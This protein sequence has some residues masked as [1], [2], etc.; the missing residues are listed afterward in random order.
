MSKVSR[1]FLPF[2]IALFCVN[3]LDRVNI[4]F[5]ALQMN[6]DLG[7][8]PQIYGFAAGILF[9]S[10]TA[11]EIP[12]NMILAKVGARI[13]IARIMI[14]WGIVGMATAFVY[15]QY[16]LYVLRFALGAAEAGFSPGIIFFLTLWFPAEE[17]ASA[18][19]LYLIGNPI[20]V[21]IGAPLSTALLGL[22][23]YLGLH[24][25]QWLFLLEGAPA[26]VLGIATLWVLTDAPSQ[27]NWLAADEREWLDQ[28]VTA[29]NAAKAKTAHMNVWQVLSNPALLAFSFVKFCVLVAFFGVTLWLP[30]IVKAMGNLTNF[31]V[32]LISAIPYAFSAVMSVAVSRHSDKTGELTLHI[33]VP[34]LLGCA[35][36]VLAAITNNP[37]LGLI[38]LCFAATGVWIANTV[39]WAMP[40][41][42]LTGTAAATGF[43][44][45]NSVGNLGGF[46]GPYFTGWVR[47][48]TP[49]FSWAL[50]LLGAFLGV[51]AIIVL[52]LGR[53]TPARPRTATA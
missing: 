49:D 47:G 1:R 38:G 8:T 39:F 27:A 9:V 36:F 31:E 25:W 46:F 7:L 21:V 12:S 37:Y 48:I 19:T 6:Q 43:A 4:S 13:W 51:A 41:A 32:G 17:R 22:Q 33:V 53:G 29:E 35:G 10:Y 45:I 11:F 26:I 52:I 24:G 30:Q 2:V 34:A 28:R 15:D 23:G 40:A 5:A 42:R 16:S 18:I 20:S 14:T 44:M 3:F 50:V